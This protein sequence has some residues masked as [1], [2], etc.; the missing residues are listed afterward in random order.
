M[1]CPR[2]DARPVLLGPDGKGLALSAPLSPLPPDP[3]LP[4][5][6]KIPPI[7]FDM[8]RVCQQCGTVYCPRISFPRSELPRP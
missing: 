7:G 1:S 3:L 2:C 5:Y 8:P 4:H 6:Q